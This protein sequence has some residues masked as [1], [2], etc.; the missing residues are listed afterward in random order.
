MWLSNCGWSVCRMCEF[1]EKHHCVFVFI[2]DRPAWTWCVF[3][4][5][6]W[7]DGG[8][9]WALRGKARDNSLLS[10]AVFSG[11]L[12]FISP[13]SVLLLA[14]SLTHTRELHHTTRTLTHPLYHSLTYLFSCSMRCTRVRKRNL[15]CLLDFEFED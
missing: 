11:R 15:E 5:T 9:L 12:L 2:S 10:C 3:Q 1:G 6:R 7:E 8:D 4:V 14:L 13:T